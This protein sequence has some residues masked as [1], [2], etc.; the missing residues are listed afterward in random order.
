MHIIIVYCTDNLLF[1]FKLEDLADLQ[2]VV[3]AVQTVAW[4]D[5]HLAQVLAERRLFLNQFLR[6]GDVGWQQLLL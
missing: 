3:L 6:S 1:I 5:K 2:D 4:L